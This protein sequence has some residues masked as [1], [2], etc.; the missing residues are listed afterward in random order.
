VY[1]GKENQFKTR[2]IIDTIPTEVYQKRMME[3]ERRAKKEGR[4]ITT[5]YR[6]RQALNL[7][8][9]NT[10]I[11]PKHVRLLYT[12]RW[13]IELMFKIWKSIGEID[14][15]K[16]MK[17]ERFESFLFAQLIW[18]VLNWH[19][20]RLM[21]HYYYQEDGVKISPFKL[22]ATLK[23]SIMDFRASTIESIDSISSFIMETIDLGPTNLFSEKKK[24]S[25]TWSFD[26]Y[27]LF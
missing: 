23:V 26:I 9:T 18:I 8:I 24:N 14:K 16:K 17:V 5:E 25:K 1:L 27:K 2:L 12:L 7:F 11:S 6:V 10:D 3:A 19:I 15:V 13:Q 22:Y 4:T 20:M 21:V